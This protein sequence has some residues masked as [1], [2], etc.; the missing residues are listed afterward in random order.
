MRPAILIFSALCLAAPLKADFQALWPVDGKIGISNGSDPKRDNDENLKSSGIDM[1]V[2][3]SPILGWSQSR[4]LILPSVD[5]D[6]NTANSV[7]KVD[8]DSGTRLRV[9]L[10]SIARVVEAGEDSAGAKK[11]S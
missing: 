6:F 4:W 1:T 11:E 5:V 3:V 9:V 2:H 10:S 8:E 7:L